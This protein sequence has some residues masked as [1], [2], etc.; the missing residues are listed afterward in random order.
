MAA[1]KSGFDISVV[2]DNPAAL[3]GGALIGASTS[4]AILSHGE[5]A[6]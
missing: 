3:A 4:A 1:L 5:E 2:I 6:P